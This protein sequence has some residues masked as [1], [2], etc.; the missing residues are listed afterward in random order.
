MARRN[1][2]KMQGTQTIN[3][4]KKAKNVSAVKYVPWVIRNCLSRIEKYNFFETDT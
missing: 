4:Y 2:R 1:G 3:N